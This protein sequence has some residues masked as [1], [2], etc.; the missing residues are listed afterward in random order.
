MKNFVSI[1]TKIALLSSILFIQQIQ[2]AEIPQPPLLHHTSAIKPR[3]T[4]AGGFLKVPEGSVALV[5]HMGEY[6]ATDKPGL[7]YHY[8]LLTSYIRVDTRTILVDTP[9]QIAITMDMQKLVID[10]SYSYRITDPY[11]AVYNVQNLENNLT[12]LFFQSIL[13]HIAQ[14]DN[15]KAISLDKNKFSRDIKL[16]LNREISGSVDQNDQGSLKISRSDIRKQNTIELEEL[17]PKSQKMGEDRDW[18]VEVTSVAIT[19]IAYPESIVRSMNMQREA[20]Y[21]RKVIETNATAQRQKVEIEAEANL[22]AVI[23]AAEAQAKK[24]EI[25]TAIRLNT[26]RADADAQIIRAKA[27]ADAIRLKAEAEANAKEMVG[28]VYEGYPMLMNREMMQDTV[29]ATI[30]MY[31][32]PNSKVIISEGGKNGEG[33]FITQLMAMQAAFNNG[34]GSSNPLCVAPMKINAHEVTPKSK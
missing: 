22:T 10:G 31:S 6:F 14:L 1:A 23:K 26:A 20:E 2:G 12:F 11:K 9:Q 33:S 7:H 25:E 19:N 34:D 29:K 28:K 32:A 5:E 3:Y 24:Q 8:P 17:S 4:L 15:N 16:T 18:G 21:Q 30:N 27:D 13:S